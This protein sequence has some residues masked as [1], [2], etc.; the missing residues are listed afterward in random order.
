MRIFEVTAKGFE[1]SGSLDHLVVWVAAESAQE[2]LAV[3]NASAA[4]FWGSLPP[5]FEPD[6]TLPQDKD[7][8]LVRLTELSQ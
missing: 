4:R 7:E 8:L 6:F 1:G 5:H 2:V 3:T